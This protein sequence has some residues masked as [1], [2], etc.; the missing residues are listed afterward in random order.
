M[1]TLLER[2][3]TAVR[4]RPG[5]AIDMGQALDLLG[6]DIGAAVGAVRQSSLFCHVSESNLRKLVAAMQPY[7]VRGGET[8]VA[9]GELAR[10]FVVLM[11]GHAVV[12]RQGDGAVRT[13]GEIGRP[14]VA[15]EESL[16]GERSF[17][18]TVRMT[19]DGIVFRLSRSEFGD[20]AGAWLV[21]AVKPADAVL[22]LEAGAVLVEITSRYNAAGPGSSDRCTSLNGL[23]ACMQGQPQ[24]VRYV[25][26]SGR[27]YKSALAA[28]LLSQWGY[29]AVYLKGGLLAAGRRL[30]GHCTVARNGD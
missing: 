2:L 23:R 22:A 25:C 4:P 24:D 29:N 15:G 19:T 11:Q 17:R 8:L 16:I 1:T 12:Q 5:G 7:R 3:Q 13:I 10:E 9:E 26:C 20:F 30:R 28:F 27:V 6:L 21:D 14:T 18:T